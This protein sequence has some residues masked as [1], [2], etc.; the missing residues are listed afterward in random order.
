MATAMTLRMTVSS[1]PP[2]ACVA[3]WA[4]QRPP[5]RLPP[6]PKLPTVAMPAAAPSAVPS[7]S[8]AAAPHPKAL[9]PL[10]L[11]PVEAAVTASCSVAEV[12]LV[13]LA[14]VG[15][16]ERRRRLGV[17]DRDTDAALA[18]LMAAGR[19]RINQLQLLQQLQQHQ[20]QQ[21]LQQ[22][23]YRQHLAQLQSRL[24][25]LLQHQQQQQQAQQQRWSA[26]G[27]FHPQQPSA[28]LPALP[29][30]PDDGSSAVALWWLQQQLQQHIGA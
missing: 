30:Q 14:V 4:S 28:A 10:H 23:Q 29:Y 3:C 27:A 17:V 18:S 7:P 16:V 24:W 2:T 21:Q 26:F 12:E 11:A 15:E 1:R 25:Q 8:P 22:Q 9:P 20:Y 19:S 6:L 13:Q 5:A